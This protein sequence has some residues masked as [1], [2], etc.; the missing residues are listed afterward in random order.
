MTERKAQDKLED[1]QQPTA[2]LKGKSKGKSVESN[3]KKVWLICTLLDFFAA[4]PRFVG[5]GFAWLFAHSS[6]LFKTRSYQT[7][8]TNLSLCLPELNDQDRQQLALKSLKHTGQLFFEAAKIWNKCQGEQFIGPIRGENE[9]RSRLEQGKGVLFTGAH[10]GNWEVALYYLGSRYPFHC[11]YRPPRQL[12]MDEVINEGRCQNNTCMVKG[13]SRGVMQLIKALKDG[14]VAA[15]LSDQEPGRGAGVFVPFCG[16]DALTMTIVQRIQQK[17]Q[18]D[19]FQVAAIKNKQ[20]TY[21]IHLDPLN[22]DSELSQQ[23]SE[24]DYAKNVNQCLEAKIRQY[25]AQYQ[26]SYK[27]FKTTDCG[28]PNPYCK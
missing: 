19:L 14:E 1:K 10:I 15:I 7:S 11:M 3:P 12:E 21:D 18:V 23:L 2:A 24:E 25:P 8:L 13:D 20:G 28:G 26:W 16:Q 6:R 22:I 9:V 27:R 5:K 4:M 17:S